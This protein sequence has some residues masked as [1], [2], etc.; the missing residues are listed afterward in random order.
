MVL[1]TRGR[2]LQAGQPQCDGGNTPEVGHPVLPIQLLLYS[3]CD[4]LS[5]HRLAEPN[6]I[7]VTQALKNKMIIPEFQQFCQR[8][9]DIFL[10][11]TQITNQKRSYKW[12]KVNVPQVSRQPARQ[13]GHLH[14]SAGEV[15]WGISWCNTVH[16]C[17]VLI[18]H[19]FA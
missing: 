19:I 6:I 14:P 17:S 12:Y 2:E 16:L 5:L 10:R 18:E 11:F 7:L 8:L 3:Q 4:L 13:R 9:K 1:P 15:R